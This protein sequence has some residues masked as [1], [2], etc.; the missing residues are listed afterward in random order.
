[1]EPSE[2]SRAEA[3]ELTTSAPP[4][5]SV[6]DP[7]LSLRPPS[8]HP[9]PS[10]PE[11]VPPHQF[12][13]EPQT[14]SAFRAN[15]GTAKR[16]SRLRGLFDSIPIPSGSTGPSK[17]STSALPT[18]PAQDEDARREE[19]RKQY[20]QELYGKCS[21]CNVRDQ[22]E[23]QDVNWNDKAAKAAQTLERWTAFEKYA[24]EKEK[25]LWRLFVELDVDGDMRLRREEVREACNR[26]G[27]EIKEG[28]LG[29]F[30]DAVGGD[31]AISFEEWRDT[32]LVRLTDTVEKPLTAHSSSRV[33]LRCLKSSDSGTLTAPIVRR[34]H[35][36][37]RTVTVR[38][39]SYANHR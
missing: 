29:E 31:G 37:P 10:L 2:P 36:S 18:L 7:R 38:P 6:S 35:S 15:E 33:Q 25:E 20:A 9:T 26:A 1:M 23:V 27:V 21:A 30:I 8:P 11:D 3:F 19:L 34:C 22:D 12:E 39:Y 5:P 24:E 13:D 14:L 28:T 16:L 4:A 17:P 32:F